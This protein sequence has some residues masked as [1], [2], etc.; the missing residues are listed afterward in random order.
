MIL[1]ITYT[2][3]EKINAISNKIEALREHRNEFSTNQ[4]VNLDNIQYSLASILADII[5]KLKIPDRSPAS[6]QNIIDQ[7]NSKHNTALTI[8]GFEAIHWIRII[9]HEVLLPEVIRRYISRVVYKRKV[10]RV[11]MKVIEGREHETECLGVFYNKLI[12]E[13]KASIPKHELNSI[14]RGKKITI[15]W[16]I[17][18]GIFVVDPKKKTA[19]IWNQY[20]NTYI[21]YLRNEVAAIIWKRLSEDELSEA[22]FRKYL[23]LITDFFD[24]WPNKLE[25]YLNHQS[26][27]KIHSL[28]VQ[29][30]NNESDL[31][32]SDDEFLKLWLDTSVYQDIEINL[33][34]PDIKLNA[35]SVYE[36][37]DE[38][39]S[40]RRFDD[41]F[42]S[43]E[44]R[45]LYSFLLEFVIQ[46]DYSMPKYDDVIRIF[47]KIDKPFLVWTML[48]KLS[49][50]RGKVAPYLLR[51]TE[52]IPIVLR[53][54]D[55]FTISNKLLLGSDYNKKNEEALKIADDIWRNLYEITLEQL[56]IQDQNEESGKVLL[57]ILFD[58]ASAVFS[59]NFNNPQGQFKHNILKERYQYALERLSTRYKYL[60]GTIFGGIN[61]RYIFFI[62]PN[63][64]EQFKLLPHRPLQSE[65]V[66]LETNV[67]DLG[68]ELLKL[69]RIS[70]I[71]SEIYP[72]TAKKLNVL[73]K[74]ITAYLYNHLIKYYSSDIR[75]VYSWSYTIE[76]KRISRTPHAFGQETINW[77]FLYIHLVH[78]NMFQKLD[79]DFQKTLV[80][81]QTSPE[82]KYA[83]QN[84][85]QISKI[86]TYLSSLLTAYIGIWTKRSEYE[87]AGLRV[88]ETLL[89]LEEKIRWYAVRYNKDQLDEG[90]LNVFDDKFFSLERDQY[91]ESLI[92]LLFKSLN[93]F[94]RIDRKEFINQFF[95]GSVDIR[96]ML[97]GLNI[98]DSKDLKDL[99][100][101]KV[102]NIAIEEFNNSR[103]NIDDLLIAAV[104]A[105]NSD[106]HL[107]LVKPLIDKVKQVYDNIKQFHYERQANL[108]YEVSLVLSYKEG[109]RKAIEDLPVPVPPG[110]RGNSEPENRKKY[111]LAM[112]CIHHEKKYDKGIEEFRLLLSA[113]PTRISYAYQL[114]RGTML[115]AVN[116]G[117]VEEIRKAKA[118]WDTFLSEQKDFNEEQRSALA[119]YSQAIE[120]NH[121]H[122][123]TTT[124]DIIGFELSIRKLSPEY[125][126][127]DEIVDVIYQFY[128]RNDMHT[129]ATTY[130]FNAEKYYKNNQLSTPA[131]LSNLLDNALDT[132][133]LG[134]L[135]EVLN[136]LS[137]QRVKNI[138]K[139]IPNALNGMPDLNMFLFHETIQAAKIL[140]MKFKVLDEL[141]KEDKYTDLLQSVL[142]MRFAVWGWDLSEQ[143]RSGSSYA[144]KD[145]GRLDL[146]I[147]SAGISFALW[148]AFI[149]TGSN[150]KTTTEHI[151]K[152]LR[153]MYNL[154]RYYIVVYF[155]GKTKNFNSS[156]ESYKHNV[157]NISFPT[158]AKI[159]KKQG[160]IPLENNFENVKGFKTAK[161][162]HKHGMEMYHL[163]I[164]FNY[165][166]P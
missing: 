156:W 79:R 115:K 15:E 37:I 57:R 125:L 21:N 126:Y 9:N 113:N 158:D 133:T 18:H 90:R 29:V 109:N 117:N 3:Q 92:S 103:F 43:S 5:L 42:D 124:S 80:F 1:N 134:K 137:S 164:N 20:N 81:D 153:Y 38:M 96:N 32:N 84:A 31:N 30:L 28:S 4:G 50:S 119:K 12:A 53:V 61:P 142:T 72:A 45:S 149:L 27:K 108:S 34:P 152:S 98:L 16:L 11:R 89:A 97:A 121:L 39:D 55:S 130:L 163:F 22:F 58:L 110:L 65:R 48:H 106:T 67:I 93:L 146:L 159:D 118:E 141:K 160:F 52:L 151:L 56:A 82:R 70:P 78:Y 91:E 68:I 83:D 35:S 155:L 75:N 107:H 150:K 17:D 7:Y 123:Y 10:N 148:E 136:G 60:P 8:Q 139:V 112:L 132:Q 120:A 114:Y 138:P 13:R 14:L 25:D 85:D 47:K 74:A 44:S 26:L 102:N 129:S 100:G 63:I 49:F 145:L 54:V 46:Y 162:V 157:L 143:A 19:Y 86:K 144:K 6:L 122:Y 87:M 131:I 77:A 105:V 128:I 88:E 94:T 161:T 166:N 101:E 76:R 2:N 59:S 165:N 135:K 40:H 69:S 73:P 111:F 140:I 66:N 116:K 71:K 23:Q 62:L 33:A 24:W 127:D 99:V 95:E 36:L 154:E 147:K 51:E 104:E 64:F 41:I